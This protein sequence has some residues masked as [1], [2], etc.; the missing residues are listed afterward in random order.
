MRRISFYRV[1]LNIIFYTLVFFIVPEK[2]DKIGVL[3]YV[4][5]YFGQLYRLIR[6]DYIKNKRD[7]SIVNFNTLFF[8]M[9]SLVTYLIPV[10][11]ILNVRDVNFSVF[12][13][14]NETYIRKTLLLSSIAVELYTYG[15]FRGLSKPSSRVNDKLLR[16]IDSILSIFKILSV[17][18]TIYFLLHFFQARTLGNMDVSGRV[19]TL[20]NCFIILPITLSGYSNLKYNLGFWAFCRKH[21]IIFACAGIIVISMLSI[22]DRTIPVAL[23]SAFLFIINEFVYKIRSSQFLLLIIIGVTFMF[24]ISYTRGTSQSLI[25]GYRDFRSSDNKLSFFQDV[26][27]GNANF[28]LSTEIVEKEGL[29]KPLRIIPIFLAPIPFVPSLIKNTFFEG[30]IGTAMYLTLYNRNLVFSY[31][32]SGVGTHVVA[33][34]Y[35]SWGILGVLLFFYLFGLIVGSL[36]TKKANPYSLI[37]YTSLISWSIFMA[38]ASFFDPYRDIVWMC[39]ILYFIS[40]S[41][42]RK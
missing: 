4:V 24:L 11:Y 22:G 31:G 25:V 39:C 40:F 20:V 1:L 16:N 32:E 18:V 27:P 26:Y 23:L 13:Q 38:R 34:I 35:L 9:Y 7:Y 28:I 33:D 29:Y 15:Y 19:S 2:Y 41:V 30:E 21:L 10:F 42:F 5:I 3:L 36:F 6:N 37:S 12:V 8:T 17:I 14:F